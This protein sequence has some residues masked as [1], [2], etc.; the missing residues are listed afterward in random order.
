[1]ID[2][3]VHSESWDYLSECNNKEDY[4]YPKITPRFY[5][6]M[7]ELR[8]TEIDTINQI[9]HEEILRV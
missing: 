5:I 1:M 6:L 3:F 4:K 8:K 7:P 9:N 2:F